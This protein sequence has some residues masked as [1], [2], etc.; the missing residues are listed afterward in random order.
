MNGSGGDN[1]ITVPMMA[2][3]PI[4]GQSIITD[5]PAIELIDNL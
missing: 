1:S 2:G 4:G 5:S 3:A